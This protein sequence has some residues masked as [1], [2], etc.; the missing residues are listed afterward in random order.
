MKPFGHYLTLAGG[1]VLALQLIGCSPRSIQPTTPTYTQ[2]AVSVPTST[3]TPSPTRLPAFTST[4]TPTSAPAEEPTLP[5]FFSLLT[6][7]QVAEYN[8]LKPKDQEVLPLLYHLQENYGFEL[9]APQKSLMQSVALGRFLQGMDEN[10]QV[11]VLESKL[12]PLNNDRT[13]Y[14]YAGN[15]MS[16]YNLAHFIKVF[17]SLGYDVHSNDWSNQIPEEEP[18]EFQLDAYVFDIVQELKG[19]R[20]TESFGKMPVSDFYQY[21]KDNGMPDTY[22]LPWEHFLAGIS[23]S[24]PEDLTLLVIH[25]HTNLTQKK[26]SF[27]GLRDTKDIKDIYPEWFLD[28]LEG[29]FMAIH[30]ICPMGNKF[31]E[32]FGKYMEEYNLRRAENGREPLLYAGVFPYTENDQYRLVPLGEIPRAFLTEIISQGIEGDSLYSHPSVTLDSINNVFKEPEEGLHTSYELRP[33]IHTW[34]LDAPESDPLVISSFHVIS[35]S[36]Y[37][38]DRSN[39]GI[40][41]ITVVTNYNEI[42]KLPLGNFID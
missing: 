16:P 5:A 8:K 13:A 32:E 41:G 36:P 39:L 12:S 28:S 34:P 23:A 31:S 18:S 10:S 33:Y 22:R 26:I 14:V 19:I 9:I 38:D 6:D 21:V 35:P 20:E 17:S 15:D 4:L 29:V 2:T 24:S 27:T 11:S 1:I 40:T 3:P 25:S 42:N 7:S 37:Q 30:D